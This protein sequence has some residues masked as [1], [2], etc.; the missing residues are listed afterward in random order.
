MLKSKTKPDNQTESQVGTQA[1]QE[2]RDFFDEAG[3]FLIWA[4]SLEDDMAPQLQEIG[5]EIFQDI[6]TLTTEV[7]TLREKTKTYLAESRGILKAIE[8]EFYAARSS[9]IENS[10]EACHEAHRCEE[11]IKSVVTNLNRTIGIKDMGDRVGNILT[12]QAKKTRLHV[13]NKIQQQHITRLEGL[14]SSDAERI[15]TGESPDI[16]P[17]LK[18]DFS[19][20]IKNICDKINEEALDRLLSLLKLYAHQ[21]ETLVSKKKSIIDAIVKHNATVAETI[22]GLDKALTE[23]RSEVDASTVLVAQNRAVVATAIEQIDSE[24]IGEN[25]EQYEQHLSQ[26]HQ[27]IE[28][29]EKEETSSLK[30]RKKTQT[31]FSLQHSKIR[32]N[33]RKKAG[34]SSPKVDTESPATRYRTSV[35]GTR[36]IFNTS[37]QVV[38]DPDSKTSSFTHQ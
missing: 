1:T 5:G 12:L 4:S 33:E 30:K 20:K 22:D 6:E 2:T 29:L 3:N 9:A 8:T 28:T 36:L 25:I 10:V 32:H 13:S 16:K 11:L 31:N 27:D 7:E 17:V 38:S 21:R 15:S 14:I 18:D 35:G 26:L 19:I 34:L 24:C 37:P 23:A